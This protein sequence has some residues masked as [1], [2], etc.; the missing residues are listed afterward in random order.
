MKYA[1][2]F[3]TGLIVGIYG[4]AWV[5]EYV[6]PSQAPTFRPSTSGDGAHVIRWTAT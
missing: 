4:A 1:L 5:L 2:A 3:T 6:F